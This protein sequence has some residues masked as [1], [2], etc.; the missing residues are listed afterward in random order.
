LAAL[1]C[2]FKAATLFGE[3]AF[4]RAFLMLAILTEMALGALKALTATLANF[5]CALISLALMAFFSSGAAFLRAFL[6]AA[7]FLATLSCFFKRA[8]LTGFFALA[9]LALMAAIFL[10]IDFLGATYATFLLAFF[11]ALFALASLALITA[12]YSGSAL[13]SA[14]LRA[15]TFLTALS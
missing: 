13:L 10:A 12:F 14:L 4:L 15:R 6:S 2:F 11:K 7:T 5:F 3:A 1:S 9:S 8:L